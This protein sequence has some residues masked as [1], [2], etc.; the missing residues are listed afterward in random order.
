MMT[1]QTDPSG[2]TTIEVSGRLEHQDYERV[3]PELERIVGQG[4]ARVLLELR[5][6]KGFTPKALVD[7]LKFDIRH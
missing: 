5:D 4:N 1:L 6:F 7:E 3:L 2:L